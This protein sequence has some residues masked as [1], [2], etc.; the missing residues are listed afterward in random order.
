MFGITTSESGISVPNNMKLNVIEND[1]ESIENGVHSGNSPLSGAH[2]PHTV[3]SSVEYI[4]SSHDNTGSRLLPLDAA[5][6]NT[7]VTRDELFSRVDEHERD[8]VKQ[9]RNMSDK[10]AENCFSSNGTKALGTCA[11]G[12]HHES[13]K[14]NHTNGNVRIVVNSR[15]HYG[16]DKENQVIV[17]QLGQDTFCVSKHNLIKR[18]QL[19]AKFFEE[20]DISKSIG[21]QKRAFVNGSKGNL[22]NYVH[23]HSDLRFV[24]LRFS[25]YI[26]F[27][28]FIKKKKGCTFLKTSK[29]FTYTIKKKQHVS[30]YFIYLYTCREQ[31]NEDVS[32]NTLETTETK[33]NEA[34]GDN[35]TWGDTSSII[36]MGNNKYFID[37]CP[38]MFRKVLEYIQTDTYYDD[39]LRYEMDMYDMFRCN[40]Q[41]SNPLKAGLYSNTNYN[42]NYNYNYNHNNTMSPNYATALRCVSQN[43]LSWVQL[44]LAKIA[45]A[46]QDRLQFLTK[47]LDECLYYQLN[48]LTLSIQKSEKKFEEMEALV[49]RLMKWSQ[50]PSSQ[51]LTAEKDLSW[52]DTDTTYGGIRRIPFSRIAFAVSKDN[53][54]LLSTR[55]DPP[56]HF[57]WASQA[58]Y[59]DE[60]QRRDL[61]TFK[62]WI[63]HGQGGWKEYYWKLVKK[64]AFLFRDSFECGKFVHS[65][66]AVGDIDHVYSL[67][68]SQ[69]EDLIEYDEQ[70]GL[71]EGFA[72]LVL[73][74]DEI[75]SPAQN[76]LEYQEFLHTP[77]R[78]PDS[79]P[80]PPSSSLSSSVNN[81]KPLSNNPHVH[82]LYDHELYE[83]NKASTP[84]RAFTPSTNAICSP[85]HSYYNPNLVN[86][87]GTHATDRSVF[88]VSLERD[89]ELKHGQ[90]NVSFQ[91]MDL[92]QPYSLY[93]VHAAN[94]TT[95]NDYSLQ[96]NITQTRSYP[97]ELLHKMH[98]MVTLSSKTHATA[99]HVLSHKTATLDKESHMKEGLEIISE[100][101]Q[102][103]SLQNPDERRNVLSL[104]DRTQVQKQSPKMDKPLLATA[105]RN[106][107]CNEDQSGN[108]N[109]NN[110]NDDDNDDN[111]DN[112][113]DDDDNDDIVNGNNNGKEK[114]STVITNVPNYQPSRNFH[115]NVAD[116]ADMHTISKIQ[117]QYKISMRDAA[118]KNTNVLSASFSSMDSPNVMF[119]TKSSSLSNL[120]KKS[121][122]QII[123][124]SSES[125]HN[126]LQTLHRAQSLTQSPPLIHPP[127]PSVRQDAWRG[128]GPAMPTYWNLQTS[129]HQF[130]QR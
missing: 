67:L 14:V 111:S 30:N 121:S 55:F 129:S 25:I 79:P 38:K 41:W 10:Y 85:L 97:S 11:D 98:P 86:H 101:S 58:E 54:C 82:A 72:G 63:H 26:F 18:S 74:S 65:G 78:A 60:F 7:S 83:N 28:F 123:E 109:A 128:H 99:T 62:T 115:T 23:T 73:L 64:V 119:S 16:I 125:Y 102:F 8:A 71:V 69:T 24:Y 6:S 47:F 34:N 112:D 77:N 3:N 51:G 88:P 113:I 94:N 61:R 117:E 22:V 89:Q 66:M 9:S 59:L 44:W 105:N 130:M 53:Y 52:L 45:P 107:K 116:M 15:R 84:V 81:P 48:E 20:H 17:L 93:N 40:E 56:L 50:S 91:R 36:R 43:Q 29:H 124:R 21:H 39:S 5:V 106:A 32:A 114:L 49:K 33:K 57:R 126:Y 110:D 19:F 127:V 104:I 27:F 108:N 90:S 92:P 68:H 103:L 80:P 42:Y 31:S 2:S 122:S 96:P 46:M 95:T 13:A 4:E 1:D 35:A 70:R 12:N 76:D 37:R 87:F 75:Y 120:P 118:A 100:N